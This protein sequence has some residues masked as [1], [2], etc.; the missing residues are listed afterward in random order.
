MYQTLIEEENKKF[1]KHRGINKKII[2]FRATLS[3]TCYFS[4][5][6]CERQLE[7]KRIEKH[8]IN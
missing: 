1:P 6:S 2:N 8:K 5:T 3:S 7:T 4:L